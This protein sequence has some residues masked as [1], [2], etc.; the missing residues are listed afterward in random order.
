[1][2]TRKVAG[3]VVAVMPGRP[4]VHR[5][6]SRG[7]ER[8]E[9]F[10]RGFRIVNSRR[11]NIVNQGL[12]RRMHTDLVLTNPD[13][14]CYATLYTHANCWTE[15]S[16]QSHRASNSLF[17]S[18]RKGEM[19]LAALCLCLYNIHVPVPIGTGTGIDTTSCSVP[20]GEM[21]RAILVTLP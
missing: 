19:R 15:D 1:M 16:L 20:I 18:M 14:F 12:F 17:L 5:G 8:E 6:A 13:E 21:G 11:P 4:L 9:H 7:G 10:P 2:S 3:V